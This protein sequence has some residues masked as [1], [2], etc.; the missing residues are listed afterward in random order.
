MSSKFLGRLSVPLLIG[1]SAVEN[2]EQ[3]IKHSPK[4]A[5]SYRFDPVN[6][7][8]WSDLIKLGKSLKY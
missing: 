5:D 4:V 1:G 6:L 2:S 8:P 7:V 3:H